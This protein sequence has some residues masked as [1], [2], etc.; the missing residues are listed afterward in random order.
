[1]YVMFPVRATSKSIRG[2]IIKGISVLELGW[3][4]MRENL[5]IALVCFM[6]YLVD[7]MV[8]IRKHGIG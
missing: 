4:T 1:M 6:G 3:G 7:I 2:A 8:P 5:A